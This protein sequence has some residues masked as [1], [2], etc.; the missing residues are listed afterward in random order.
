VPD[1]G[2]DEDRDGAARGEHHVTAERLLDVFVFAPAELAMSTLREFEHFDEIAAKGRRRFGTQ[3]SNARFIGQLVVGTGRRQLERLIGA[4]VAHDGPAHDES[5]AADDDGDIAPAPPH[6]AV[7]DGAEADLAIPDYRALSASQVVRR[8]DGL[9]PDEL[10]ALY[11]YEASTRG[12]RTILHRA[13]QLLGHEEP[14]VPPAP[15]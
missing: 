8:L 7:A 4:M 1:A 6:S 5:P 14:P 13:Q 10:E 12:R 3:V 2:A 15:D 9:G 11:R